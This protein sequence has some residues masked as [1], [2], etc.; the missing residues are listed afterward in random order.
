MNQVVAIVA[1]VG[2]SQRLTD[3]VNYMMSLLPIDC[4]A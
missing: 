2:K 1:T 4:F 3:L